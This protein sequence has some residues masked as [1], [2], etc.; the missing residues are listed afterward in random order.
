MTIEQVIRETDELKPNTYSEAHKIRWLSRVDAMVKRL[1]LDPHKGAD[2][3]KF[4]G[5]DET[6][7]RDTGLLVPE[8][9]DE[10]YG[11][12]LRAQIDY[13]NRE[14]DPYNN[15]I[16]TFHA[17]FGAYGDDYRSRHSSAGPADFRW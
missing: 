13:H 15:E 17:V 12:Y 14:F 5:Y 16:E 1:I 2:Q 4:R 7:P 9:Y 6:T 11:A 10:M 8:P 3:I